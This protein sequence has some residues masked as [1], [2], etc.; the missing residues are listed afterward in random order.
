MSAG[1]LKT[2]KSR[3]TTT[4]KQICAQIYSKNTK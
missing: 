2:V 4:N 1:K 3:K